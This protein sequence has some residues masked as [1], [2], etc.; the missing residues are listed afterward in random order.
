MRG[1]TIGEI[2]KCAE[3]FEQHLSE[4]YARISAETELPAV[5]F[6]SDY[7]SRHRNRIEQ[8]LSKMPADQMHHIINIPLQ[9]EPHIP[10]DHCFKVITLPANAAPDQILDAAMKFDDCIVQM[11]HQISLQPV[12]TDVKDFFEKLELLEQNDQLELKKIKTM[13]TASV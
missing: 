2:L 6:L 1:I 12:H 5:R 3:K 9:Y 13:F 4:F 11:F 10:G 7:M 8:A